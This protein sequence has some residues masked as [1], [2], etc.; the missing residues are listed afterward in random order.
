MNST[1]ET[2]D[3]EEQPQ[4]AAKRARLD[5]PNDQFDNIADTAVN[6][7]D[8]FYGTLHQTPLARQPSE[9]PKS[10]VPSLIQDSPG[11]DPGPF[12]PGLGL[13]SWRTEA[14]PSHDEASEIQHSS[15]PPGDD[16]AQTRQEELPSLDHNDFTH[17]DRSPITPEAEV[18]TGCTQNGLAGLSKKSN[19]GELE[20]PLQFVPLDQDPASNP[21]I[22]SRNGERLPENTER[23]HE[24]RLSISKRPPAEEEA[25]NAEWRFDSSE[26]DSDTTSSS[27]SSDEDGDTDEDEM[28]DED[29]DDTEGFGL[30]TAE[31]QARILMQEASGS[32]EGDGKGGRLMTA[33]E[34]PEV[35]VEKPKV[36]ITSDMKIAELGHVQA[37]VENIVLVKSSG[38]GEHQVLEAGAVVCLQNRSVIGV[39]TDTLGRVHEPMY[40][41][42]FVRSEEIKEMG[43]EIGSMIFF[44]ESLAKHV[45]TQPMKLMK[46]TDASNLHDEETGDAVPEF[47]DDEEEAAY[48]LAQKRE[49]LGQKALGRETTPSLSRGRMREKREQK[50]GHTPRQV[51]T[52]HNETGD[53]DMYTPLQRP[54]NLYRAYGESRTEPSEEHWIANR[55]DRNK[56]GRG[57]GD[58]GRPDRGRGHGQGNRGRSNR[59]TMPSYRGNEEA[60][61]ADMDR[62]QNQN[63]NEGQLH[64][65][66][67]NWSPSQSATQFMQYGQGYPPQDGQVPHFPFVP[68]LSMPWPQGGNH[69]M[70]NFNGQSQLGETPSSPTNLP[71]GAY[72]NRAFFQNQSLPMQTQFSTPTVPQPIQHTPAPWFGMP[73]LFSPTPGFPAAQPPPINPNQSAGDG[74]PPLPGSDAFRAAQEQLNILRGLNRPFGLP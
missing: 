18:T 25:G 26:I 66:N 32:G 37:I 15:H 38:S 6:D 70:N 16:Q 57:R 46:G 22:P 5:D 10:S 13:L 40:S 28:D 41:I 56:R 49:R 61:H 64:Q 30:L 55:G 14:C 3:F 62:P 59:T 73:A 29:K 67:Q 34:L 43:I 9:P 24:Q 19:G 44:V 27:L 58:R 39:I 68:Q 72:L 52:S 53:D 23:D 60:T 21:E 20:Q 54:D 51:P 4:R 50:H 71:A 74:S 35:I 42:G 63:Y 17:V 33:N 65:S 48:K 47:S 45:F 69:Y 11:V 7:E 1:H 36:A 8:D 31:E 2:C 12:I